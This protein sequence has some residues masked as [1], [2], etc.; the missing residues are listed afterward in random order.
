MSDR[1]G[2]LVTGV[3][4]GVGQSLLKCLQETD[5]RVVAADGENLGTGLFVADRGYTIPYASDAAFIERVLAVCER[6]ACRIVFPG[7]DA[8]LSV[9]SRARER[10]LAA[11]VT[12]V[13]SSPEVVEI[14]DDKLLT[15]QFLATAGLP[16]PRTCALSEVDSLREVR[17]PMVLKP[18]KGGKRSIGVR[19]A[20]DE[21]DLSRQLQTLDTSNY[22]AQELIEG[23]EY[24]CGTVNFHNGC[25][26]AI[27]MRRVLR[28][29][30]TYKAFVEDNPLVERCVR[31]AA[32]ALRPFGACNFQLRVR[33]GVPY[34]FEINARSSG[35]TYCRSLA[36]FNEPKMIADRLLHG[37]PPAYS[38]RRISVLRYWNELVVDN[39]RIERLAH[40]GAVD[41]DGSRL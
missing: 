22:V 8:E 34:V 9:L 21:R 38:I 20:R 16:A 15:S 17:F 33:D 25:E 3:G 6:E 41:G 13:V 26:G 35:T 23:H 2:I 40:D 24:T 4:G 12:C 14:C 39:S 11:G 1:I 36:G 31:D 32:D 30:D 5:Y 29:G 19:I 7:L 27:V 28:D 37:I 10:F 18:M